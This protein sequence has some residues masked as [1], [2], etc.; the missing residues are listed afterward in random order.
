MH[1]RSTIA[2][3]VWGMAGCS[4]GPSPEMEEERPSVSSS[5]TAP[6][7]EDVTRAPDGPCPHEPSTVQKCIE[8]KE[9]WEYQAVINDYCKSDVGRGHTAEYPTQKKD[10]DHAAEFVERYFEGYQVCRSVV[11]ACR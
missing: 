10:C 11:E 4:G 8:I 2:L 1:S 6:A 7:S 9:A 3:L 5:R